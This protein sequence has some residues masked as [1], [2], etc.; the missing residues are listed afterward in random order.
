[1]AMIRFTLPDAT[2]PFYPERIQQLQRDNHTTLVVD[3]A[4]LRD[5]DQVLST[6]IISDFRRYVIF[7]DFP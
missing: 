6:T 5:A 7:P 1:M 4:H 3:M 2:M